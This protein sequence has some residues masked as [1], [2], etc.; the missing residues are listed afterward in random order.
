MYRKL[1]EFW[2]KEK[3]S[4][5]L[6][7]VPQDLYRLIGEYATR[8]SKVGR[9]LDKNSVEAHLLRHE[10]EEAERLARELLEIRQEKILESAIRGKIVPADLF[11]PEE[12]EFYE[13]LKDAVAR[14]KNLRDMLKG[15]IDNVEKA[16]GRVVL[17]TRDVPAIVG[18]D[19]RKYGPFKPEDVAYLPAESAETLV[20]RGV[21]REVDVKR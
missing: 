18:V 6:Q 13:K 21:A 14:Q 10:E 2:L 8:I 9:M 20:K 12:R 4:K 15:P 11:T 17:F 19:L 16:G 7:E 5:D 3:T 1:F